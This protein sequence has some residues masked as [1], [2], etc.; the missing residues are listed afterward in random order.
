MN[1][2]SKITFIKTQDYNIIGKLFHKYNL[3]KQ[4]LHHFLFGYLLSYFTNNIG[5]R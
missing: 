3:Q 2:L 5:N 4:M 1:V